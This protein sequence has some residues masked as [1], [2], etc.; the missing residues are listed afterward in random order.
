MLE[1]YNKVLEEGITNA[2]SKDGI[3]TLTTK[4]NTYEVS[5][6]FLDYYKVSAILSKWHD[7]IW[8]IEKK[9]S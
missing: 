7:P 9:A 3:L 4:K 2:G 5:I 6:D 1:I 8:K